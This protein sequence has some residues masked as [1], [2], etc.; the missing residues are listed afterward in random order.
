MWSDVIG[1][2][3]WALVWLIFVALG[4]FRLRKEGLLLSRLAGLGQWALPAIVLVAF[5]VRVV[6]MFLLPVGAGFDIDSFRLVGEAILN[7]ED[8]YTSAAIGRHPYLPFQMYFIGAAFYGAAASLVPFVVLVKTLPVLADLGIT[9]IIFVAARHDQFDIQGAL[10][11]SLLY[12]LSPISLM[13]SAYHGQFDSVPL[14]LLS[15][16]WFYWHF[17][18]NIGRSGIALG[19][20]ILSKTWPIVYLPVVFLRIRSNRRK[21][22]FAAEAL[23]IPILFTVA[24]IVIFSADPRPLLQRALT[25][26]GNPGWWGHSALLATAGKQTGLFQPLYDAILGINRWLLIGVGIVVVWITRKQASVDSLTTIILSIFAVSVGMGIQWLVWVV[27]FAILAD[28]IKWLRWYTLAVILFMLVQL[29]GLHMY[30]WLQQLFEPDVA[31]TIFRLS[32][33]PAWITVV[34]WTIRRLRLPKV[35]LG[36]GPVHFI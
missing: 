27:P 4:F 16:A 22:L 24:Y 3:T 13:V 18:R 26:V 30:P 1:A 15:L 29:Y 11:W 20:A 19:F 10:Y 14:L 32:S 9:I 25:H 28:D 33:V 31:D 8:V 6:P 2:T 36:G 5:I 34:L 17:G 23:S 7:G 21:L 35:A 12:A